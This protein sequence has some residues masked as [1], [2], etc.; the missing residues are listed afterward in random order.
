VTR[1]H[2]A[3]A[4]SSR[5]L[6]LLRFIGEQTLVTIP[7][8]AYLT[9]RSERTARW[10]RTRWERAGLAEGAKF[11][12]DGPTVVWTTGRGL[13]IAGLPFPPVRPDASILDR[14]AACVELRLAVERAHPSARFTSYRELTFEERE[15]QRIPDAVIDLGATQIATVVLQNEHSHALWRFEQRLSQLRRRNQSL[16]VLAAPALVSRVREL[17]PEAEVVPWFWR[18]W[19]VNPPRLRLPD[20]PATRADRSEREKAAAAPT[21]DHAGAAAAPSQTHGLRSNSRRPRRRGR[22]SARGGMAGSGAL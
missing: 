8:L 12:A 20:Q 17:A 1:Q 18:R 16:L 15:R 19:E 2:G 22:G 7:Q 10:L 3:R 5:D 6:Q 9:R 13:R 11:L 4:L 21:P 14:A